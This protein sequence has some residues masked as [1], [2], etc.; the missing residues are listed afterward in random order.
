MAFAAGTLADGQIASSLGT[1]YTVPGATTAYIKTITIFNTNAATQTVI[2]QI[3]RSGGTTRK[4]R[5]FELA[6]NESA[7]V[8]SPGTSLQLSTGDIIEAVTTT[9]SAVDYTITG[10]LE[11]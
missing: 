5:Q 2:V 3:K 1:L 10:V 11:T 9:A 6:Q 7:D 8:L 4:Y